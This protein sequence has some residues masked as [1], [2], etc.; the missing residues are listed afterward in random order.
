MI[1]DDASSIYTTMT[2]IARN[3]YL[4]VCSIYRIA[5]Y[6]SVDLIFIKQ[7]DDDSITADVI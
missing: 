5:G 3:P 7:P 6:F 1:Y 2:A 4:D